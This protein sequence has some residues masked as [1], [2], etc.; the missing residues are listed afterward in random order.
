[1]LDPFLSGGILLNSMPD[2]SC[3]MHFWHWTSL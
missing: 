1:M 3:N 2:N